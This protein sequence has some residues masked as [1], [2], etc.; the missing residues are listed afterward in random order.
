MTNDKCLNAFWFWTTGGAAT[1][2][3]KNA[4]S[5]ADFFPPAAKCAG[6]TGELRK[7]VLWLVA[8]R[9][10]LL[11]V[12][13]NL[14]DP[15]GLLPPRLG[16]LPFLPFLNLLTLLLTCIYTAL[17]W[18]NWKLPEQLRLQVGVDLCLTTLLVAHTRGVDSALVS[19]YVLII[20]YCSLTMGRN[21]GMIG[22]ALS[23]ILYAGIIAAG[24]TGLI[25]S[26]SAIDDPKPLV[27]RAS[28]NA[29]AFFAVAF[30]GTTLSHRLRSVQEQLKEK[31]DSLQQLQSLNEHIVSSIR[32][33]LIT[34]DLEGKIAVFNS[35]AEELTEKNSSETLNRPVRTV[36][37][38]EL[39][40]K[41]LSADFFVDIRPLRYQRWF[42]LPS[43]R[44]R[45]LGFSVSPLVDHERRLLGYTISFQDLTEI[46]RLEEEVRVRDRMAAVGRMAAGI[47]HEIRNPLTS[48]R[49][50]VEI[51]RGHDGLSPTDRRL[52]D[53]LIRESDRLNKFVEDF[54]QFARPGK[55]SKQ[56]V[57][58]AQ[59]LA[60]SATLL[61]NSPEVREK[62]TVALKL[63]R[64]PISISGNEDQLRQV[65][66]NL[67][68]N[69]LRAMPG[70]GTLTVSARAAQ[71]GEWEVTFE[72]TGIGMSPEERDQLFQPFHSGFSGGTGL[73]LSIVFQIIEDLRG[74]ISIDS[75]K[76]R[77]TRVTLVFPP[78]SQSALSIQ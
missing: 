49:G 58:L 27:Y 26:P 25:S 78:E 74:R 71:D 24:Q 65:F 18:S 52:L 62:H 77:G 28:I 64:Q 57:D 9:A 39:W 69:A 36:I 34:A 60:D 19:L 20:I 45:F 41:I 5:L 17:W 76:G 15:L 13:L 54:L 43:G 2:T 31:I 56:L 6:H 4:M 38:D 29:F 68:Q 44:K 35:T 14:A 11:F 66:W 42:V 37:G 40:A 1:R 48:M 47:A 70:G 30:L 7:Q 59:L 72:D 55:H 3:M 23:T 46:K 61:R 33:G 16:A 8:I 67:A 32:S 50:S 22:A 10:V 53:I 51:L 21:A 63:E 75:E 12:G 73:G